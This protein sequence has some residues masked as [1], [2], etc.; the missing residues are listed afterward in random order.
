MP[1]YFTLRSYIEHIRA[2]FLWYISIA[3]TLTKIR[4]RLYDRLISIYTHMLIYLWE[5]EFS[6]LGTCSKLRR[7]DILLGNGAY[8]Y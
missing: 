7:A 3:L 6:V 4:I 5:D 1:K 8:L 2:T